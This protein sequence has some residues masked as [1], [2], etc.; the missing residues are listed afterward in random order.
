MLRRRL[1]RSSSVGDPIDR[2]NNQVDQS[3]NW[4]CI[5]EKEKPMMKNT[6]EKQVEL[7]NSDEKNKKNV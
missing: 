3:P 2:I 6:F 7:K 1:I 4:I 5:P